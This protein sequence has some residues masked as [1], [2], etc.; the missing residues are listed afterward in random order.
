MSQAYE[1]SFARVYNEMWGAFAQKVAHPIMDF[2]QQ[3]EISAT[4]KNILDLCCGTGQLA[5]EFLKQNYQVVAIDLSPH[6]LIYARENTKEY[7]RKGLVQFIEADASKFSM[8]NNFGLAVSTY[9]A[10]NH[11]KG[12]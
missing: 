6:M 12:E 4:N 7:F 1:K 10:I 8:E 2:Y 9:D 5:L 3:T 11:L